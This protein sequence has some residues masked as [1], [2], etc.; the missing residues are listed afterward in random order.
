MLGSKLTSS[1]RHR[2]H[3]SNLPTQLMC[4]KKKPKA[5]SHSASSA[6]SSGG[7]SQ[8]LKPKSL[9]TFIYPPPN[10]L[11]Y[12]SSKPLLTTLSWFLAPTL[13]LRLALQF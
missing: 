11:K 10:C 1:E 13:D 3:P 12:P 7:K 9:N 6:D 5:K 4:Q 8:S 2:K